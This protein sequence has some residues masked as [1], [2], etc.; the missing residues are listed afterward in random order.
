MK[1]ILLLTMMFAGISAVTKA[2]KIS[3]SSDKDTILQKH[4]FINPGFSYISNLTYAGR[5]NTVSTPVLTPYLNLI[6]KKGFFLSATGYINAGK[7]W[8]LDGVSI[9]PGY[10]FQLSKHFNGY[11]SATKYFLADSSSLILASIKGSID[12]GFNYTS[13]IINAGIILDYIFGKKQ[14]FLMGINLNKDIK[15]NLF[16]NASLKITPTASFTAGTQSFY[17]TYYINTITKKRRSSGP[18]S[19]D[20][21]LGGILDQQE[22]QNTTTVTNTIITEKKQKEI[23]KFN[24]LN[25]S[26][27]IPVSFHI[28]KFRMSITPNLVFPFNQVNLSNGSSVE[29]NKPFFF[30][31]AGASI[32]F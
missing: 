5:K 11:A 20:G 21:I 8:S 15:I 12:A 6:L 16:K 2:Q 31:T 9:T 17:K 13:K 27:D 10:V 28:G 14:D 24:P 7:Q 25:I 3:D 29:L 30:Y 18:P 23:R 1:R 32:V 26:F 22:N 19:S 4:I